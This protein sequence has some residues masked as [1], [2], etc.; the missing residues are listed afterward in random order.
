MQDLCQYNNAE[1]VKYWQ[2]VQD[3]SRISR[4]ERFG[5]TMPQKI[6]QL[7]AALSKAGFC[8]RPGKGSHTVLATSSAT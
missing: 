3:A 8:V 2:Y 7:K 1:E 5:G 6:R 4:V